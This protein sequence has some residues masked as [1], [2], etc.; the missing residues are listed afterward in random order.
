MPDVAAGFP[1]WCSAELCPQLRDKVCSPLCV[2]LLCRMHLQI[3]IRFVCSQCGESPEGLLISERGLAQGLAQKL[4]R[5]PNLAFYQQ[6]GVIKAMRGAGKGT[7]RTF[8][9]GMQQQCRRTQTARESNDSNT[10][11][12]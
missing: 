4:V 8:S 1:S 6:K 9:T 10:R 11:A 3:G 12:C 5:L 7:I 2:E